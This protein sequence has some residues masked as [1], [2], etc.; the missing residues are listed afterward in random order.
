ML[1]KVEE[2]MAGTINKNENG[3]RIPP[4]RYRRILN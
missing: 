3:L 4:V 2:T 1:R